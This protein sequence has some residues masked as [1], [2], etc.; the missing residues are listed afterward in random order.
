[1]SELI[2]QECSTPYKFGA[3]FCQE[4]GNQLDSDN[5]DTVVGGMAVPAQTQAITKPSLATQVPAGMVV[6]IILSSARR[7]EIHLNNE[8]QIGRIDPNRDIHPQ[9]D[10]TVDNGANLGVSRLHASLQSTKNGVMLVDLGSTNGTY[11]REENLTPHVPSA[12]N[13]GDMFQ[14]GHLQVQVFFSM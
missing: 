13:N 9:L 14:L 7:V 5:Y 1:M 12:I 3:L 8:I 11:L 2:C 6:F 10:L 4:C